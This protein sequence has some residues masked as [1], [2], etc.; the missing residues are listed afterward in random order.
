MKDFSSIWKASAK[1]KY[2][3]QGL[4]YDYYWDV[5][6]GKW[7]NWN[8]KVQA[9]LST[10]ETIFSKIFVPTVHTTRLRYLLDFHLRRKKPIMFIGSAGTGKTAVIKDYLA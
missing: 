6:E 1:V 9:Y 10:D 3:E 5:V 2:P 7:G 8:Q 4:C